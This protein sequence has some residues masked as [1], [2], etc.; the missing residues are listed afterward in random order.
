MWRGP[1]CRFKIPNDIAC[2]KCGAFPPPSTGGK[3]RSLSSDNGERLAL[4]ARS[5]LTIIF[6]L[7]TIIFG[8][9]VGF[10]AAIMM[11]TPVRDLFNP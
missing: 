5:L 11:A 6:G 3:Q 4:L 2:I 1:S 8:L 9:T 10:F 7:I